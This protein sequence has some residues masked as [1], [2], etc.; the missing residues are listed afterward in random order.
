MAV[1]ANNGN[2]IFSSVNEKQLFCVFP[3]KRK[4]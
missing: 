2:Y 1:D 4:Q 3:K